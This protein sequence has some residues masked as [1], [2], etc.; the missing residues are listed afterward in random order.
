[1]ED[2]FKFK[3]YQEDPRDVLNHVFQALRDGFPM[4]AYDICAQ[5]YYADRANAHVQAAL[6]A[7]RK[8]LETHDE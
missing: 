8:Y 3:V 5:F 1:M 2:K 4:Q 6:E 7:H